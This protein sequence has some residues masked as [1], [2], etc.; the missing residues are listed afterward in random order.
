VARSPL[1]YAG[2]IV[3]ALVVIVLVVTGA[4]R[5]RGALAPTPAATVAAAEPIRPAD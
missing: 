2:W 1:G 5:R 3:L 4:I